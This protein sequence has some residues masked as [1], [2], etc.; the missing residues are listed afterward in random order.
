MNLLNS[1]NFKVAITQLYNVVLEKP[2]L[3]TNART[4]ACMHTHIEPLMDTHDTFYN[5]PPG[6]KPDGR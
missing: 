2:A 3:N 6:L 4:H 5:F 1:K